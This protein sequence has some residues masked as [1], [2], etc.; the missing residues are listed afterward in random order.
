MAMAT[1]PRGA[2]REPR[3][4]PV[5]REKR[6]FNIFI[7]TIVTCML[8]NTSEVRD[9]SW[10]KATV[11]ASWQPTATSRAACSNGTSWGRQ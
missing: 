4:T 8:A 10:Q 7:A 3:C 6:S 9:A 11:I 5:A 2:A 1:N